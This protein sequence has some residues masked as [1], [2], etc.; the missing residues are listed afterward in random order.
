[1]T[2]AVPAT[3]GGRFILAAMGVAGAAGPGRPQAICAA[4]P[5]GGG[6]FGIPPEKVGFLRTK[7]A[8]LDESKPEP[9]PG[10]IYEV[11]RIEELTE[12]SAVQ[13]LCVILGAR[14]TDPQAVQAAVWHLNCDLSWWRLAARLRTLG[15]PH[16]TQRFF[17][18]GQIE[19]GKHLAEV[20]MR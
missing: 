20:A 1:M 13:K 17:T 18:P 9:H 16:G 12:Q 2:V 11:C 19:E 3:I 10:M 14:Q 8:C 15:G 4:A 5:S 6:L 7:T